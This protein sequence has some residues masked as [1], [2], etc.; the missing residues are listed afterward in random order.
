MAKRGSGQ[1]TLDQQAEALA[2]L[3]GGIQ[4]AAVALRFG[5]TK[6]VIAGLW[7]RQGEPASTHEPTTL[8]ERC[9]ALK[10][11]MDHVLKD[12]ASAVDKARKAGAGN[13]AD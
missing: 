5:V 7:S 9:D 3:R 2:L 12:T 11:R 6:N 1:L 10:V 8:Y 13:A 4:Q